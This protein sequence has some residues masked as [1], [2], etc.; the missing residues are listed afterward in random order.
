M[1]QR[2]PTLPDIV[3]RSHLR[4]GCDWLAQIF[5]RNGHRL[6]DAWAGATP[7]TEAVLSSLQSGGGAADRLPKGSMEV[8]I[9]EGGTHLKPCAE[10]GKDP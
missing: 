9:L 8:S 7:A 6:P 10:E 1:P 2:T 5:A 4:R 3:A